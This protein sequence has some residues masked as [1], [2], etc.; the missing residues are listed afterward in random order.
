MSA[1]KVELGRRLFADRRLSVNGTLSCADC[2]RPE[3]AYTDGRRRP[4][5]E[6]GDGL[7]HNAPSLANVVYNGA[8]GWATDRVTE[9]EQQMRTPLFA[10]H[11]VELG[12]AGREAALLDVL[13]TDPQASAAFAAAFPA[14]GEPVSVDNLIRAI[15]AFERTLISGRSAFDRY[16]FDDDR[17]A[18]SDSARRGMRLF[19]SRR[20]GCGGCHGGINFS[21]AVKAAGFEDAKALFADNGLTTGDRG[22]EAVTGRPADRGKFKVPGLRNVQLT[23]PY[24][25]DGSVATLAE[26]VDLYD[27]GGRQRRMR[28]LALSAREKADLIAF[29]ASLTDPQFVAADPSVGLDGLDLDQQLHI[30][31]EAKVLAVG[32]AEVLAVDHRRGIGAADFLL[33]HRVRLAQEAVDLQRHRLGHAVQRQFTVNLG[34]CVALEGGE[35]ALVAG[36]R[37]F[38]DI[39]HV[40]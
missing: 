35:L 26:V 32:D 31:L 15:A 24:M 11:P 8:Y 7:P 37:E 6:L 23:A 21:G 14:D 12:L 3:L 16:V 27:Q 20:A 29:L 13:R 39:E 22:L 18:M 2:H 25:H 9:L 30:H 17:A 19:Y 1:P 10:V 38:S 36:K 34:R 33:G 40:R 4:Q 5:G 28:P